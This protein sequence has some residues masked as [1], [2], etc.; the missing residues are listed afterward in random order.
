MLP[1]ALV[2]LA[3][4]LAACADG[5]AGSDGDEEGVAASTTRPQPVETT[6]PVPSVAFRNDVPPVDLGDG[7]TV[8]SC[9]GD[10]PLLCVSRNG[11][12]AGIIE[13][14]VFPV[15]SFAIGG[16]QDA[17]AEGDDRKALG[18]LATDF[19]RTFR[20]DRSE[21]CGVDYEIE[22]TP[23]EDATVLGQPGIRYGYRAERNGA[24]VEIQANH[25]TIVEGDV[26]L[27]NAPAYA[28]GPE[29]C[30]PPEGEFSPE[31]LDDFLPRLRA[32]VAT[33]ER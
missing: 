31:G 6:I 24:L 16:F 27:V 20:A 23:T 5:S 4:V 9:E 17:V 28:A 30:V 29:G 22:P 25:G 32:L 13:L 3:T 18:F 8:Q 12:P 21:A 10:A 2:L 1:L 15:S 33:A 19:V 7:W 11:S 26:V 14:A